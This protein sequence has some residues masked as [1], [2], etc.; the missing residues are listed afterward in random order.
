VSIVSD[1]AS[2]SPEQNVIWAVSRGVGLVHVA[3][4]LLFS[5]NSAQR[6]HRAAIRFH[7]CVSSKLHPQLRRSIER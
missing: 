7:T 1:A 5:D 2:A 3:D 6:I 4:E